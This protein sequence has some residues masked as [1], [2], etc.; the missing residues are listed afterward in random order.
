MA[1]R[2]EPEFDVIVSKVLQSHQRR[3]DEIESSGS[4]M[5]ELAELPEAEVIDTTV[6]TKAGHKWRMPLVGGMSTTEVQS[7]RSRGHHVAVLG[8]YQRRCDVLLSDCMLTVT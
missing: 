5:E 4:W 3:L 6:V 7:F 2:D 8:E 1:T